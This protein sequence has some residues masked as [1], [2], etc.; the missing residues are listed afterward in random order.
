M[1]KLNLK[2]FWQDESGA[3]AMEYGILVG[4]FG[5]VLVAIMQDVVDSLA[6]LFDM[7][8]EAVDKSLVSDNG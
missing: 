5:V 8:R 4:V 6:V 3:T 1:R 7:M 2:K